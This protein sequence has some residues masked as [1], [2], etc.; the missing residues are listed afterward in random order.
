MC[1]RNF[2]L[3]ELSCR[4][5]ALSPL[6]LPW[7]PVA[8]QCTPPP[9]NFKTPL[10]I[11]FPG[12]CRL[13]LALCNEQRPHHPP[14]GSAFVSTS[15]TN[16]VAPPSYTRARGPHSDHGGQHA[17]DYDP[18]GPQWLHLEGGWAEDPAVVHTLRGFD[19][20]V[21]LDTMP[22]RPHKGRVTVQ[23]QKDPGKGGFYVYIGSH[24]AQHRGSSSFISRGRVPGARK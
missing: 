3:T 15:Y 16:L 19:L 23:T 20:V 8:P 10:L 2:K 13:L 7:T 21:C 6:F 18:Y 24:L 5:R 11:P 22:F 1:K 12:P 4:E 17:F 9:N 14:G